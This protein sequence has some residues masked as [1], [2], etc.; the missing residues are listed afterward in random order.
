[1]QAMLDSTYFE[2]FWTTPVKLPVT[3]LLMILLVIKA[4]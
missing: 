1:M 3:K 2:A 4:T